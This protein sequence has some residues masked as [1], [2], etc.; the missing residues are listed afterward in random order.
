LPPA[1]TPRRPI[2]VLFSVR[3]LHHGG[4]ERDVAKIARHIDRSR[5]EPHVACFTAGG[6]R[7]EE[8]RSAGIPVAHVPVASLRSATALSSAGRLWKYVRHHGIR[9]LHAWDNSAGLF[10]PAARLA[11]VPV[12]LASQLGYRSLYDPQ[13]LKLARIVD[14]LVDGIV[15]NCEAMRRHLAD[16]EGF[17]ESRIELCYN[18]VD[19]AEFFPRKEPRAEEVRDASLVIG[20]VC[21]LREEKALDLL[22]QAFAR[23]RHLRPGIKLMFVGSGPEL[24][25]LSANAE[26]LRIAEDSVFVPTTSEVPKYLR[27]IDIF[28]LSSRSEAFS[29]SL[30]EAIACGCSA[31]GSRV[32]GTPEMLG[33]NERG[34]LFTPGNAEEL[35]ACLQ[36]LIC[37]DDLR[38][39]LAAKAADFARSELNIERA[40][41]RMS[42]IYDEWLARK[43]RE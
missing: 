3:E 41:V 32:G 34:L 29:N 12:V 5:W 7:Y 33:E 14:R 40:C 15:V 38:T 26:R 37:D 25:R 23:V 13:S 17:P 18:G 11:R 16:D 6:L 27:S 8:L 35:A 4:I 22:Q 36:Q 2:P 10:V 9:V 30:L 1:I 28:V 42:Q 43:A 24:A 31:V 19:T 20:T 39:T 21:V